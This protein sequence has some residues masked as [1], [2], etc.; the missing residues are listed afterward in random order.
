M[1][2]FGF[3]F[4]FRNVQKRISTMEKMSDTM[5]LKVLTT[6]TTHCLPKIQL[7]VRLFISN[8]ISIIRTTTYYRASH[9]R[10]RGHRLWGG[11]STTPYLLF[12]CVGVLPVWM[13]V[14]WVCAWC[15]WGPKRV[16][17]PQGLQFT[18]V[19]NQHMG[20]RNVDS[21]L[22][23]WPISSP[24]ITFK[25]FSTGSHSVAQDGYDILGWSRAHS[26]LL[27]SVSW[28][29][30]TGQ[31]WSTMPNSASFTAIQKVLLQLPLCRAQRQ[32]ASGWTSSDRKFW[33]TTQLWCRDPKVR[34]ESAHNLPYPFCLSQK[35]DMS[36]V[37]MAN[38]FLGIWNSA[39][40]R[41]PEHGHPGTQLLCHASNLTQF[42]QTLI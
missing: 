35:P 34:W 33:V 29:L 41:P 19:V 17:H 1:I 40:G 11:N 36:P 12:Q 42:Y 16:S 25:F 3:L 7:C 27:A 14:H 20:V 5:F 21:A 6:T 15:S 38:N 28:V 23:S 31:V 18:D 22:N 32:L 4:K 2:R 8:W 37:E 24:L 26:N 39:L 30:L 13:P 9:S 10:E